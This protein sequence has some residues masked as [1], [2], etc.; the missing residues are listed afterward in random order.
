M[1]ATQA[2]PAGTTLNAGNKNGASILAAAEAAAKAKTASAN[3][4]TP[5]KK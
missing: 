3:K 4:S 2:G 5:A 1:G